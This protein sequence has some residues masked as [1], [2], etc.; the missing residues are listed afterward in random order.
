MTTRS[1][2]AYIDEQSGMI[3]SIYCHWDG[4]PDHQ[5]P[6]LCA[7]YN[8]INKIKKLIS[9]GSISKL[10]PEIGEMAS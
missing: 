3:R 8:D 10:G 1:S 6:I 2:I 7:H 9:L 5:A 4:Y